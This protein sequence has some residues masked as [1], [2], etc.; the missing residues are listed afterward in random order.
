M[1]SFNTD[2]VRNRNQFLYAHKA[3]HTMITEQT[4]Y[5]LRVE[6]IDELTYQFKLRDKLA[7]MEPNNPAYR[8]TE[9]LIQKSAERCRN[10][11][12]LI[13]EHANKIIKAA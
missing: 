4:W 1:N 12:F 5:N 9:L 3:K 13:Q 10:Y 6:F 2:T 8:P 7:G 11:D